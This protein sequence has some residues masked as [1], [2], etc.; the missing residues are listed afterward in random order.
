[1]IWTQAAA[2]AGELEDEAGAAAAVKL[3]EGPFG[4][5]EARL[6]RAGKEARGSARTKGVTLRATGVAAAGGRPRNVSRVMRPF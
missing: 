1:M 5:A 2:G 6:A 4:P 3:T